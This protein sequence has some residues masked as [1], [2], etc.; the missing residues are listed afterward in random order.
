MS[1]PG[2]IQDSEHLSWPVH[3]QGSQ[4]WKGDVLAGQG[5]LAGARRAFPPRC[6]LSAKLQAVLGSQDASS[7]TNPLRC[8][9][10][11]F[12]TK[13]WSMWLKSLPGKSDVKQM[14]PAES[15]FEEWQWAG[16][17]Y[18][19]EATWISSKL[20]CEDSTHWAPGCLLCPLC[21]GLCPPLLRSHKEVFP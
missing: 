21:C 17:G 1:H 8:L 3:S 5:E 11:A 2:C 19:W 14:L 20:K 7:Q 4:T 18:K 16:D 15:K 6:W 13:L 12:Y 10:P 9:G